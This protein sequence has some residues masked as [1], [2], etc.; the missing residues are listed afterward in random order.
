MQRIRPWLRETHGTQFE[1]VR[2]FLAQQLACE[3]LSSDQLR[4][5]VI[6]VLA[7]LGC[8]GPLIIRLYLP[9]YAYLQS[10]P[11]PGLYQAAVIADRLFFISLS[12]ICVGL[13]SAFQWQNP[14]P[15]RQD[16]LALKPLPVRLR[17][18]FVAR[19]VAGAVIF[20][21]VAGDLNLATSVL[22]P[23]ITSG[24]WQVPPFGF[25]YVYAHA[26]ATL[27]AGLF[28]FLAMVAVQGVSLTL[29][30]PRAFERASVLIQAILFTSFC[31]GRSLRVRYAE[32]AC[33][34][35]LQAILADVLSASVVSGSLRAPAGHA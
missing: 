33:H 18:V 28:V 26:A 7:A 34:D 6:T 3:L 29:L 31:S 32:L 10:L 8:A 30:S 24:K 23:F 16:Y 15:N 27:A 5:L 2:H 13:L 9:K 14:F 12:M 35:R 22:F 17:Q 11:G 21:V 20:V 19:F 25:R 1:L 4:R